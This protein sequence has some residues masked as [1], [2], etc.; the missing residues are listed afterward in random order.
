[1]STP[2]NNRCHTLPC[3]RWFTDETPLLVLRDGRALLAHQEEDYYMKRLRQFEVTA[4]QHV[5]KWR[6]QRLDPDFRG[7]P[8][9]V[10]AGDDVTALPGDMRTDE[11]QTLMVEWTKHMDGKNSCEYMQNYII[12]VSDV[13]NKYKSRHNT[14]LLLAY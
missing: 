7:L 4:R 9:Y 8:G 5:F 11:I 3:Y 12:P 2:Y 13:R 14:L 6:D 10:S 1:M